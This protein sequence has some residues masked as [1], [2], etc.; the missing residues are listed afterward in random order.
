MK[1]YI[2]LESYMNIFYSFV[3]RSGRL[4]V[5]LVFRQTLM[6]W[7]KMFCILLLNW[8]KICVE[9]KYELI[10][11]SAVQTMLIEIFSQFESS[12]NMTEKII[13][14]SNEN[15]FWE[16]IL[17]NGF[18]IS[19]NCL[20]FSS[21]FSITSL[22]WNLIKKFGLKNKYFLITVFEKFNKLKYLLQNSKWMNWI[23]NIQ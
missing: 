22:I 2:K 21:K 8:I 6:F 20:S 5:W 7:I 16:I 23:T 17:F 13:C 9:I 4:S 1:W 11:R 10:S 19:L 18:R 3:T 12:N 14:K 15:I